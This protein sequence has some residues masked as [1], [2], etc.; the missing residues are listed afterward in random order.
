M[1]KVFLPL[2]LILFSV[3]LF[4]LLAEGGIRLLN[5]TPPNEATGFFWRTSDPTTGW[6]LQPNATGRWFNPAY[7]YDTN[8][9]INE[10][11]LR[12]PKE[13]GYERQDDTLRILVLGDSYVEALQ[14][15][16]ENTFPQQLA[17]LLQAKADARGDGRTIEVINA[18]VSG[19]GTDQQLLWLQHE[20]VTYRPDVV[21]L[22]VYPGN[23][24]MNNSLPLEFANMGSV[25]KPFF[26]RQNDELALLNFPYNSEAAAEIA[27]T[28]RPTAEDDLTL[29][30]DSTL[31]DELPDA[32]T[33]SAPLPSPPA[34]IVQVREWVEP[35]STLYRF[36]DPRI[37]VMM[38]T[39]AV[40]LANWGMLEPGQE[41]SDADLGPNYIPV[42]Y[43]IYEQPLAPKWEA[44]A[45][46]TGML[47]AKMKASAA[48]M[49][50]TLFAT[51]LT[52]A[53]Q[54]YPERW[55]ENLQNYEA[56][57][58][59]NWSLQQ[60]NALAADLLAEAEIP[61]LDLLPIFLESAASGPLLHLRDD[62]HWTTDGHALA[63][64]ALAEFLIEQ[65]PLAEDGKGN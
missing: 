1:K 63:A 47:F 54:V 55:D 46:L 60:P 23:D 9:T 35:R 6:S 26:E 21:L 25:R 14:I 45:A 13:V 19:W 34:W 11:G 50:A 57:Q 16:L 12:S 56:M 31:E 7:E 2:G 49:D 53:E 17:R 61:T 27:A 39:V 62:G 52:S 5:L 64:D 3:L 22:A 40:Q 48:E 37:R 65:G 18:G 20:G 51:L 15:P 24:F 33:V 42:T 32:T 29:E 41:S 30:D 4:I 58:A 43:G 10:R 59:R 28:L 8:I 36:L 38:P 44:S